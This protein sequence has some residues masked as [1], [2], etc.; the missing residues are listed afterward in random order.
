V[1]REALEKGPLLIFGA[2][3]V[4]TYV[5]VDGFNF[6]YGAVRNT[7][8]KWL[9]FKALFTHL[10]P[11]NYQILKIKYFTAWVRPTPND[12][13]KSIRQRTFV[14][15]LKSHI[16]EIEVFLGHFLS[17]PTSMP[18][19]QPVG[20]QQ[21]AHVIKTEE[22]G[23]DVNLAVH[24]LNDSWLDV[25]DCA[26]IVSNDSD[27][28]EALSLVKTQHNKRIGVITPHKGK[29]SR[30]LIQYA[31][32]VRR[33]RTGVLQVSQLPDPIPNTSIRKPST[34]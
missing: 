25:Y 32:F 8:Y 24:V 34:W 2:V 33:V 3:L 6:Y 21:F 22:K 31:D 9:D 16:P 23:S 20:N 11:P 4:R 30:E 27:L 14:R 12:P 29:Q 28:A 18:L 5:Y 17:H 10:L 19:V 1:G 15:A 13:D 7:P 26:V